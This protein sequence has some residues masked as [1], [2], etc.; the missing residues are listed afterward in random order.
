MNIYLFGK[1]GAGKDTVAEYLHRY[2]YEPYAL[3]DGIKKEFGYFNFRQATKADRA[4][5]IRIGEGYKHIYSA[6]VWCRQTMRAIENWQ[7]FFGTP[8]IITDGRFEVEY[9]YFVT[10]RG[11]IPV[12]LET[13]EDVRMMRLLARDGVDQREVLDGQESDVDQM[14]AQY[15]ITNY[16]DLDHLYKQLDW[17]VEE[18]GGRE[19]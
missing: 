19:D 18:I 15:T 10:Q 8:V 17:L 11:F 6:D 9:N 4:A 12:K 3:A 5:L 7:V 13:P 2:N 16:F 1:A 14:E